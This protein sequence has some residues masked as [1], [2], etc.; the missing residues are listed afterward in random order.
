MTE[1]IDIRII[2]MCTPQWPNEPWY[3]YKD[4]ELFSDETIEYI[5]KRLGGDIPDVNPKNRIFN[6]KT[7]DKDAFHAEVSAVGFSLGRMLFSPSMEV[8]EERP[9]K[10][11]MYI[12]FKTGYPVLLGGSVYKKQQ[13]LLRVRDVDYKIVWSKIEPVIRKYQER[14]D[15]TYRRKKKNE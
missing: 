15:E 5:R 9:R 8:F 10:T 1:D 12:K 11:R 6:I 3:M 13:V 14:Y 7:K 2:E 4:E